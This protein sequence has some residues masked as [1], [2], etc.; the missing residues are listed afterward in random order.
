MTTRATTK[1]VAASKPKVSELRARFEF[2]KVS[3]AIEGIEFAEEELCFIEESI[4]KRHRG[5]GFISTA[6]ALLKA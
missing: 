5:T 6:R 2:I 4:R 3:F 1:S